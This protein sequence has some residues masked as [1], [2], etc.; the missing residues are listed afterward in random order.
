MTE[1]I[2]INIKQ[3]P[4]GRAQLFAHLY[5]EVY[6]SVYPDIV[7]AVIAAEEL[8]EFEGGKHDETRKETDG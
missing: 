5:G 6:E 3:L 1:P 2:E 4:G 8:L 7:L